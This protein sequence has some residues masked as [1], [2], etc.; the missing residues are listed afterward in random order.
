MRLGG[1]V[2]S[3]FK[4]AEEFIA[5]A[6]DSGFKAVVFPLNHKAPED[7]INVLKREIDKAGIVIAEVGAWR[8]NPL[9]ASGQVRREALDNIKK[10]LELAERIGAR[11][12][13]NVA[14]SLSDKWDGPHMNSLKE[15]TFALIVDTVR[16]II[17]AVKPER[18]F[19]TLETMPWMF[20]Y[21]PGSYMRLIKAVDR[22][23]FGVH[24]DI[25]NMLNSPVL[26]YNNAEFTKECFEKLGPYIKSIHV[27][28]MAV[29]Q[30]L[31]VH[32]NEC[33]VGAGHY[34]F[35]EFFTCAAKLD[36]SMPV[37]VEH[38]KVQEEYKRSVTY[39]RNFASNM[40]IEV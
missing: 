29:E 34:D 35:K 2:V 24:L 12:C 14:G 26:L 30:R 37:L 1:A 31:T 8:N 4:G 38:I 6:V 23:A 19:Y 17:D 5:I 11:C 16:E 27:K 13:V 39:L 20:P 28:D 33:F 32:L 10:Q 40:G 9:D 15:D 18:T 22:K 3:E 36:E 7:D 25:I 21:D